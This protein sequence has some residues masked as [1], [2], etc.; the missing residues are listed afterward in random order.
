ME[1]GLLL[2]ADELWDGNQSSSWESS[3]DWIRITQR[4][5]RQGRVWVVQALFCRAPII[6]QSTVQKNITLSV[7]EAELNAPTSMAQDM[8]YVKCL[9]ESIWE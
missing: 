6:Q 8:M 1:R 2:K 5:S 9:L 4:T 7:T 3:R